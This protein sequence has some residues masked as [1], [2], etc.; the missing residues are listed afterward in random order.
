VAVATAPVAART[1]RRVLVVDD[2][3][4]NRLV[5]TRMLAKLGCEVVEAVNGHDAVARAATTELALILM[6]CQM[7]E[8]D[9][10]EATQQIRRA[11][12]SR[13]VPIVAMTANAME[14]DRDRCLL[15]GMDDYIAKPVTV[16]GLTGMLE[17]WTD[18]ARRAALE[19]GEPGRASALRA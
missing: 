16:A 5:A 9:G 18:P 14:G 7:P 8:L 4:V 19:G 13:R 15:A 10:Y 12:T 17:H 2:N 6:D 3:A 11:E 1:P